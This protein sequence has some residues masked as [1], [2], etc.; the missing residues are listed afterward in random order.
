MNTKPLGRKAYGSIGHILGSR[1]GPGDHMVH[2]GQ[3]YMCTTKV[4]RDRRVLVQTKLD[5]SCVAAA[6]LSDGT[7]VALGRAGYPADSSPYEMHHMWARWVRA[8]EAMFDELLEPDERCVGEWL[9]K[10]HGTI[11]DL[12]LRPP[13]VAFDIM[14]ADRRVIFTEFDQRTE[15]VGLQTPD[16]MIGPAEPVEAMGLLDSYGADHP[17]GVVYRVESLRRVVHTVAPVWTVDFLAKWVRPDK[18]DGAYLGDDLW[19]WTEQ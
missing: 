13:F 12:S 5:G 2:E 17:E 11:Y 4:P 18:I 16:T 9:A 19:N 1:L 6:K 10:A 15:R 14:R 7:V 8:N 3:T